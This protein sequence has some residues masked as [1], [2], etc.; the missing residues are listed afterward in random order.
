MGRCL[1]AIALSTYRSYDAVVS[2][3]SSD[4]DLIRGALDLEHADRALRPHRLP[5]RAR[6]QGS[7]PRLDMAESR[8]SRVLLVF[9]TS[10]DVF[11]LDT[12]R[13]VITLYGEA[14]APEHPLPEALHPDADTH[15]MIGQ[16][17]LNA[18]FSS[19]RLPEPR[20]RHAFT[21]RSAGQS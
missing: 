6:G 20:G 13:T 4:P 2:D 15:R 12:H 16:G 17:P 1:V 18:A 9:G 19:G 11:E 21:P 8:P 7:E 3:V 5:E 10:A 14:D